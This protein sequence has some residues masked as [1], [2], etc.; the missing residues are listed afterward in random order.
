[1]ASILIID[2]DV[3]YAEMLQQRLIRAKHNVSVHVGPFGGTLAVK[4]AHVDLVILDVF[5]PGLDGPAL[6]DLLRKDSNSGRPRV[7]LCSS[8]DAEPLRE[9]AQRHNA[10]GSI[11]KSASRQQL[12]D[13]VERVLGAGRTPSPAHS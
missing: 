5:M 13:Y 6:L 10:Q 3:V 12:L 7:I 11:P 1:V 8:M 2:D 9:L 4:R